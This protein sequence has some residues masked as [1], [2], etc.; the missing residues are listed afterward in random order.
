MT[1]A[2]EFC[3][4]NFNIQKNNQKISLNHISTEKT[5]FRVLI[6][7]LLTYVSSMILYFCQ[8]VDTKVLLQC[9][10]SFHYWQTGAMEMK[11]EKQFPDLKSAYCI[12]HGSV[13]QI[14][15]CYFFQQGKL[16]NY[17]NKATTRMWATG[18]NYAFLSMYVNLHNNMIKKGWL[19]YKWLY[20]DWNGKATYPEGS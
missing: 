16:C 14:L 4:P 20:C 11:F 2:A 1:M 7:I 5:L 12:T 19:F 9:G 3:L 6:Q 8:S 18:Q 17:N 15:V 10:T 13:L